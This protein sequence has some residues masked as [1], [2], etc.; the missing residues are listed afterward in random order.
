MATRRH[1]SSNPH[2]SFSHFPRAAP[3]ALPASSSPL[4]PILSGQARFSDQDGPQVHLRPT[5]PDQDSSLGLQL[6]SLA[7]TAPTLRSPCSTAFALRAK[8]G[9]LRQKRP[10]RHHAST[11]PSASPQSSIFLC[12]LS[13]R[14]HH[15]FSAK[16]NPGLI[17]WL[18]P[19]MEHY[20]LQATP[21]SASTRFDFFVLCSLYFV[22]RFPF[23]AL[24]V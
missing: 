3:S 24:S 11:Y 6:P 2:S 17:S 20:P 14:F 23:V 4:G 1:R 7:P 21:I 9:S 22:R 18:P 5:S 10:L 19:Q 8:Q 13:H 16:N 15:V 12:N